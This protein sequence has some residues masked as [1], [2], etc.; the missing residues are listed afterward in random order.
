MKPLSIKLPK[1]EQ[2]HHG[3]IY[4]IFKDIKKDLSKRGEIYYVYRMEKISII[5]MS[6]FLQI[7]L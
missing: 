1:V 7:D 4:R 5:N 6:T 2:T 3:E